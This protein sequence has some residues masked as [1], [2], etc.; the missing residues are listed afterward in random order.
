MPKRPKPVTEPRSVRTAKVKPPKRTRP[1]RALVNHTTTTNIAQIRRNLLVT[2]NGELWAYYVLEPVPWAFQSV[3][4]RSTHMRLMNQRFAE[5]MGH[6]IHI[7]TTAQPFPHARWAERLVETNEVLP[8]TPLGEPFGGEAGYLANAQAL[9]IGSRAY[10]HTTYLGVRVL[11]NLPG[12]HRE[13]VLAR[14]IHDSEPE[15]AVRAINQLH[16]IDEIVARPGFDAVPVSSRGLAWL[17]YASLGLGIPVSRESLQGPTDRWTTADVDAFD[18]HAEVSQEPL[19]RVLE[20]VA[21]RDRASHHRYASVLTVGRMGRRADPDPGA[22]PWM[23]FT[24]SLTDREGLPLPIEWSAHLDIFDGQSKEFSAN[25]QVQVAE[26]QA[27]HYAAHGL[28]VPPRVARAVSAAVEV[29]DR[30]TSGPAEQRVTIRGQFRVAVTASTSA[31]VND[32]ID[33]IKQAFRSSQYS[34]EIIREWGQ[35][36][37]YREFIPGFSPTLTGHVRE[38]WGAFAATAVPQA[39]ATLGDGTGPLIGLTSGYGRRPVFFDPNT[40]PRRN[41]SGVGALVAPQGAGKSYF[42]SV[43]AD[44][45]TRL[46]RM[47]IVYDPAGAMGALARLPHLAGHAREINLSGAAPGTLNPYLLVPDPT[48]ADYPGVDEYTAAVADA[49]VERAQLAVNSLVGLLADPRPQYIAAIEAGVAATTKTRGTSLWD[50]VDAV[51]KDGDAGASAAAQ[52]TA[53]AG[54]RGGTLMFP[55]QGDRDVDIPVDIT[56]SL[57]VITMRGVEIPTGQAMD[58]RERVSHA[59][60]RL[61]ARMAQLAMYTSRDPKLI[62]SDEMGQVGGG[63]ALSASLNRWAMDSRKWNTS[64]LLLGQ[65][66]HHI[67]RLSPEVANLLGFAMVGRMEDE[68][69]ARAALSILG[70]PQGHG[71]ENTLMTLRTGQFVL[72]DYDRVI[73]A[74]DVVSVSEVVAEAANT[75]PPG[76]VDGR[77]LSPGDPFA[78][79]LRAIT[80]EVAR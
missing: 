31:E 45:C 75:T 64:L 78:D 77:E 20:V 76:F 34:T 61:A 65:N 70:A 24:Q 53:A 30:R 54:L 26:D 55:R 36:E 60:L 7:R 48:L 63:N 69:T 3:G 10:Q 13:C 6:R 59:T 21:D 80:Q 58:Q 42:A 44:A 74:V 56:A 18:D 23:S 17:V 29:A 43:L 14:K 62:A 37:L 27:N 33:E 4:R 50:V 25:R 49:E 19:S 72:R 40:G 15:W 68:D 38:M 2:R 1:K 52:L 47:V 71:Y 57:T 16:K 32:R 35:F 8:D 9:I 51:S 22:W 28:S 46:G 11:T 5:L 12:S 41:Q 39:T 67:L 73:D 66:P 79:D